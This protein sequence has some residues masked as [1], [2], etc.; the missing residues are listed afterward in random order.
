M[1]RGWG[2]PMTRTLSLPTIPGEF[3]RAISK[4]KLGVEHCAARR[5]GRRTQYTPLWHW[6]PPFGLSTTPN[7]LA[8]CTR[9]TY[10]QR[11]Q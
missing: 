3:A 5:S 1:P 8:K 7:T 9:C 10:V 11:K 4:E 2:H 6:G